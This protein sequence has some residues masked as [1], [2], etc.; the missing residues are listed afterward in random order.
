MMSQLLSCSPEEAAGMILTYCFN[1][2][3]WSHY[4]TQSS[5]EIP[6]KSISILTGSWL[7]S[8]PRS[9]HIIQIPELLGSERYTTHPSRREKKEEEG[10]WE[11]SIMRYFIKPRIGPKTQ[12]KGKAP[13]KK[14][15]LRIRGNYFLH[16][17]WYS[18][19][20]EEEAF[21]STL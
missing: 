16:E 3:L 12:L 9:K 19:R 14:T 4:H 5:F 6:G 11:R 13:S 18:P 17:E 8:L 7:S 15:N 10:K 21:E 20:Q 2:V 1:P